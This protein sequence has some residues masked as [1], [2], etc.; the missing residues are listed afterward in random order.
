M[1]LCASYRHQ[2]FIPSVPFDIFARPVL[3]FTNAVDIVE[4]DR[5]QGRMQAKRG[6]AMNKAAGTKNCELQSSQTIAEATVLHSMTEALPFVAGSACE[7]GPMS[8]RIP[9]I[10]HYKPPEVNIMPSPRQKVYSS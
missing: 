1:N 9:C 6:W 5:G 2:G 8:L 10:L 3:Q 4:G 7:T